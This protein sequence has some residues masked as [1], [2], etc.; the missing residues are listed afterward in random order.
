[1][2]IIF[3][4]VEGNRMGNTTSL[5]SMLASAL[6]W[7]IAHTRGSCTE[8]DLNSWTSG[9]VEHVKPEGEMTNGLLGN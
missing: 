1:M 9:K 5:N 4:F 2:M 7:I 3:R 8:I 6:P